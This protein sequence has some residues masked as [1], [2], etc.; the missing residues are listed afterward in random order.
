M[1]TDEPQVLVR[2]ISGPAVCRIALDD[3]SLELFDYGLEEIRPDVILVSLLTAVDLEGNF[4][5]QGDS[6]LFI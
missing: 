1:L 2:G 5:A 3:G 4:P 6:E